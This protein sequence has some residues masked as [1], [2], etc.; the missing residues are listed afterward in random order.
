MARIEFSGRF[1]AGA[2]TNLVPG[3]SYLGFGCHSCAA[4][5]AALDAP[6]AQDGVEI[7]GRGSFHLQCPRCGAA[8]DYPIAEM[9]LWEAAT[10]MPGG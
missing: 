3:A 4:D 8:D 6:G 10:A 2:R 1:E 5:I 9:R 7:S